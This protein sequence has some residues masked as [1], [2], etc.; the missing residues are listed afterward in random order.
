[1]KFNE[2]ILFLFLL[3]IT[4]CGI[5]V[6][7]DANDINPPNTIKIEDNFYVDRTEIANID[8]KEYLSWLKRIF[9]EQSS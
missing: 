7:F 6:P 8:W 4:A 9:G 1:M 3:S 5:K 2:T